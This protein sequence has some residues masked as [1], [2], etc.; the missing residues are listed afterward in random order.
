[1]ARRLLRL[2]V[3]V[4]PF[5]GC[6]TA[7]PSAPVLGPVALR[8]LQ[9]RTYPTADSRALMK[10]V[11][12]A[13]QDDGFQVRTADAELGLITAARESVI[14]VNPAV[15]AGRWLLIAATYGAAALLPGPKSSSAMIEATVNVSEAGDDARLRVSF[16][17]KV[18]DGMLRVKE[19]RAVGEPRFYQEFFAKVDKG[20]F[21]LREKLSDRPRPGI[22]PS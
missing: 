3:L 18:L 9:S 21:L 7:R 11:L 20:L 15:R 16:Q 10:A 22:R 14:P 17:L 13:L 6:A 19:V 8:E 12:G 2:C 5:V 4:A 1:M